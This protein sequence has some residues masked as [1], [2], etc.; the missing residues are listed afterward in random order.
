M[1]VL[2]YN[3][4]FAVSIFGQITKILQSVFLFWQVVHA[5]MLSFRDVP[6]GR[7][8]WTPFKN[9]QDREKI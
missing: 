7:K 1:L 4:D 5:L 8:Y 2:K 3:F 6:V 9:L